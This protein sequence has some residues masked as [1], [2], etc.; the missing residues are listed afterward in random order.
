ML[1]NNIYALRQ[2]KLDERLIVSEKFA[3]HM[4]SHEIKDFGK[5]IRK[6]SKS[7]SALSN[8]IHGVTVKN[9]IADLLRDHYD[10]L[11]ND[12][13]H[14][15]ERADILQSFNNICVYM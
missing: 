13:T 1:Y 8:C 4:K 11:L 9:A 12:S 5:Y 15:D 3:D 2:C 14:H 6:H 10:R 7:K